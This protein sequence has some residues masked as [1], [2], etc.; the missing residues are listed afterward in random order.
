MARGGTR[1][2]RQ[3][4]TSAARP[5]C[6]GFLPVFHP[7]ELKPVPGYCDGLGTESQSHR[8]TL[9]DGVLNTLEWRKLKPKGVRQFVQVNPVGHYQGVGQKPTARGITRGMRTERLNEFAILN[10]LMLGPWQP[11]TKTVP[12]R[13]TT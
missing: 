12:A 6:T 7:L 1:I 11:E 9:L 3:F 8:L 10:K 13:G 2:Q 4:S 5:Y